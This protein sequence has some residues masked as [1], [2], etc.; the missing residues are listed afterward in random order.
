MRDVVT[1][2]RRFKLGCEKSLYVTLSN[3]DNLVRINVGKVGLCER[4]WSEAV[5]ELIKLCLEHKIPPIK[6]IKAMEHIKC[7]YIIEDG[8]ESCPD[9][10]A[11]FMKEVMK[12]ETSSDGI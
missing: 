2:T 9:A 5:A 7:P 11:K 8:A 10:I 3:E 4:A 6:I 1:I 12:N